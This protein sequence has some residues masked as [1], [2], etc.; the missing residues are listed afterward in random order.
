MTLVTFTAVYRRISTTLLLY[1]YLL[2]LLYKTTFHVI[3]RALDLEQAARQHLLAAP[4]KI[5]LCEYLRT[6]SS[7]LLDLKSAEVK[8]SPDQ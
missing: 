7:L 2:C 1:Y 4:A 6:Y 3:I 5:Y 8:P